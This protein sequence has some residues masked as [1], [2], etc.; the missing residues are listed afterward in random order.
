MGATDFDLETLPDL[1]TGI[2]ASSLKPDE[3]VVGRVGDRPVLVVRTKDGVRAVQAT[4][5]HY[6]APLA[7]GCVHDGQIHCPWHH[8]AFD[9]GDGSLCRPP[10]LDPLTSW[11]VEESDEVVRVVSEE[12]R[13]RSTPTPP[14]SRGAIAIIGAG[15]AGTAAVVTLRH[16]G[17]EGPI[18]LVDPDPD[19]PYDRPNLS[20]DYLAGTAPEEWLPLRTA[21]HWEELDVERIVDRVVTIEHGERALVLGTG[22]RVAFDGLLLATGAE[23]R[24]LPVPGAELD[25]VFTLRSLADC[26][27]IRAAAKSADRAVIV[28]AGFL[29]LEAAASLRNLDLE[30]AVVAPEAVPLERV[31]GRDVGT[32]LR[33]LHEERGVVFHLERSIEEIAPE[34][35]VLDDGSRLP[36]DLVLVAVGVDPRADLAARAGLEVDGGVVVDEYLAAALEDVYAVGDIARFPHPGTG[37]PIRIEH[38]AVAEAQGR[39]A[40]LN[41][42]GHQLPFRDVPFFWTAHYDTT[43]GYTGFP[44]PWD[45]V[46][47]DG[48]WGERSLSARFLEGDREVAAAFVGR[49]RESL[50]WEIEKREALG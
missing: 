40:A 11:A 24:T 15:A 42:L 29:G 43:V 23:P 18:V 37:R 44:D 47:S 25:H 5:P 31:L 46:E 49:D 19:A 12:P 3:P 16:A 4:C 32:G 9:L 34:A 13:P 39:T 33:E 17:H 50:R 8:A 41:L 27:D 1:L 6:G 38:W 2:P 28:G 10:A 36:A 20:K 22:R 21:D 35:V 7:D 45:R 48:S 14:R 26:R 30:V